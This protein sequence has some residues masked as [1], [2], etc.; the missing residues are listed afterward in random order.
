MRIIDCD[1]NSPEWFEARRGIPTCSNFD[2]IITTDGK[3]SKQSQKYMYQLAGEAVTGI[4]EESYQNA[5]MQRGIEL[6]PEARSF[7]EMVKDVTVQQVGFCVVDGYGGSPDG[8]VGDDGLI[9]IKCPSLA[10]AV[11]Y[12]LDGKLPTEYFQQVHG[13]LLVTGRAWC[14][15]ISYYPGLRPLIVRVKRDEKFIILFYKELKI[16]CEQLKQ[17]INKLGE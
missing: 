9:E 7:Y 2:K 5:A 6:E 15:F 13:L 4:K 1:Q 17:T 3:P 16:F 10:V 14:D 12:L 8:L 11:S